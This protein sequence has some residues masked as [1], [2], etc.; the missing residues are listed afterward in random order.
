[1]SM[2]QIGVNLARSVFEIAVSPVPGQVRERRRL[3]GAA[4]GPF[5]AAHPC[6]ARRGRVQAIGTPRAT[7]HRGQSPTGA[8]FKGHGLL[9]PHE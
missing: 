7:F 3:S 4:F 6:M 9:E 1:M 8:H 2:I 5:F